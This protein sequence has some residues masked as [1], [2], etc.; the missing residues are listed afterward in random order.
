MVVV[1]VAGDVGEEVYGGHGTTTAAD[2]GGAS[3]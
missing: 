3:C 2:G 1:L